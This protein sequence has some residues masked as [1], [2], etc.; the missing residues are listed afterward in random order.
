[1]D[2][3][4]TYN[5]CTEDVI[6]NAYMKGKKK[7][8]F[9]ASRKLERSCYLSQ[10]LKERIAPRQPKQLIEELKNMGVS[11]QKK[12]NE[13]YW[14]YKDS[15][16]G[17]KEEKWDEEYSYTIIDFSKVSDL[18]EHG[19]RLD[20]YANDE[21]IF[22][23]EEFLKFI[24]IWQ[25]ENNLIEN[26]FFKLEKLDF[27]AHTVIRKFA[28]E[29]NKAYNGV[30][31]AEHRG[32]TVV[33]IPLP[34]GRKLKVCISHERD[35]NNFETIRNEI[36][37][38]INTINSTNLNFRLEGKQGLLP[39]TKKFILPPTYRKAGHLQYGRTEID[40]AIKEFK[41][42]KNVYFEWKNAEHTSYW[43]DMND[44]CYH[45]SCGATLEYIYGIEG[46]D[47]IQSLYDLEDAIRKWYKDNKGIDLKSCF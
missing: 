22:Y 36:S 40:K 17:L 41:K 26:T 2:M 1:M 14:N 47:I 4:E 27:M 38:L 30:S 31:L 7:S 44:N 46:N 13:P 29:L 12:G 3:K 19:F 45:T 42:G 33:R 25:A 24:P 5:V 39:N 8:A 37:T 23:L 16:I 6:K 35:L 32:L 21:I 10:F 28:D 34:N 43:Y 15:I 18:L 20:D 9:I 11:L